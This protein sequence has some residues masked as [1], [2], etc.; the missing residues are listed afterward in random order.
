VQTLRA[1]KR[2]ND[3]NLPRVRRKFSQLSAL[4]EQISAAR[5][6]HRTILIAITIIFCS[7]STRPSPS[8]SSSQRICHHLFLS[9]VVSMAA[10]PQPDDVVV[11]YDMG[12]PIQTHRRVWTQ[13]EGSMLEGK[14]R[15]LMQND[16]GIELGFPPHLVREMVECLQFIDTEPYVDLP[17]TVVWSPQ[18]RNAEEAAD[19]SPIRRS[20]TTRFFEP[21]V[22]GNLPAGWTRNDLGKF[23]AML[24]HYGV[25][26]GVYRI[27]IMQEGFRWSIRG[28]FADFCNPVKLVVDDFGRALSFQPL[29]DRLPVDAWIVKSFTIKAMQPTEVLRNNV[30]QKTKITFVIMDSK[31]QVRLGWRITKNW[32]YIVVSNFGKEISTDG[33]TERF[34]LNDPI[35]DFDNCLHR[36]RDGTYAMPAVG[37]KLPKGTFDISVQD[38][39]FFL[40]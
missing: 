10:D 3:V 32:T 29:M 14:F 17:A 38:I 18:P 27:G 9:L 24:Q 16:R 1:I 39:Q 26:L 21:P 25:A 5:K 15:G 12:T 23:R 20:M 28:W 37:F 7:S 30:Q 4:L 6:R 31:N 36:I 11:A 13:V 8:S 33:E 34:I 2:I 22:E 19:L 40:R 35:S